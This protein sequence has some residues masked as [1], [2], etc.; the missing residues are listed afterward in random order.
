MGQDVRFVREHVSPSPLAL[1]LF[2][3]GLGIVAAH[4]G[5][6]E[7]SGWF[8]CI[9]GAFGSGLLL[10]GACSKGVSRRILRVLLP[11]IGAAL[12]LF[13]MGFWHL[14]LSCR[15]LEDRSQD[16]LSLANTTGKHII[17]GQ[18][19]RAPL[20][21]ND[22]VRLLVAVYESHIQQN[23]DYANWEQTV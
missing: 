19:I 15:S 14:D 4:T 20:P 10:F 2:P 13:S 5:Y 7:L 9:I 11:W 17:T 22:G 18:V 3:F 21:A 23:T 6:L 16:L 1:L 12:V 8:L